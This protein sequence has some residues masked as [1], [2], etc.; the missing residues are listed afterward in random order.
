[1]E[2]NTF[3][4][5]RFWKLVVRNLKSLKKFWAQSALMIA[6]FPLLFFLINISLIGVNINLSNRTSFL[7]S[8]VSILLIISPFMLFFNYNHP[9]RGFT[10]VMLGASILEKYLVM[11]LACLIFVPLAT[12]LIYCGMD[13]LLALLF[14]N[15]YHGFV[16]KEIWQQSVT[17]NNVTRVLML[18]QSILF[19]NLLF[20][21][22]KVLKTIGV[23]ILTTI[24]LITIMVITISIWKSS[25]SLEI[26]NF[27]FN[28]SDRALFEFYANDHPLIVTVL[29]S[30][31]I[32]QVVLPVV[33]VVG[34]YFILK[35]KRY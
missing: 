28:L 17:L 34:S 9:K 7:F 33:L 12:V 14:P 4:V 1:M 15:L 25:G 19:F 2:N 10:E 13:S 23:Y 29:V 16:I 35:N 21:R 22:H 6:G 31:I 20:V 8:M 26:V 3:Q 11:Q 30:R 24:A 18:Q 5:D 27:Q 32:I